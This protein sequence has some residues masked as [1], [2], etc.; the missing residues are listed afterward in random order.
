V[1]R[2][3][4]REANDLGAALDRIAAEFSVR[5]RLRV[6]VERPPVEP[7]LP[8]ATAYELVQIVREALRNA[9]RHGGATQAVVRLATHPT[10]LDLVVRDN[11]RG[12]VS[13]NGAL[14]AE[15]FLKP[16][17][18]PWSIRERAAALSASL[19]I[20]SQ[21]GRGAEIT[22]LVPVAVEHT[23]ALRRSA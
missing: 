12:F 9:V 6:R 20:W 4:G 16:A 11:G 15:G 2:G 18:A 8:A 22:L 13:A 5:D 3:G 23:I 19:R 14:D 21:P 17:A 7:A 1:L 10:H